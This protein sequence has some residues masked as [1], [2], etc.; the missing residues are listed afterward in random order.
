MDVV[1]VISSNAR[2]ANRTVRM[3]LAQL[4][5]IDKTKRV[6]VGD[7]MGFIKKMQFEVNNKTGLGLVKMEILYI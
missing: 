4:L 5:S 7:I 1:Y 2:I 6:A 3:T